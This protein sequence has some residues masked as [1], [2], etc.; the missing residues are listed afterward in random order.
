MITAGDVQFEP[1]MMRKVWWLTTAVGVMWAGDASLQAEVLNDVVL[2]VHRRVQDQP[3]NWWNVRDVA[4]LYA[5]AWNEAKR[6]RAVRAILGPLGLSD[7]EFHSGQ[8]GFSD[9]IV[10]QLAGS[11]LAFQLPGEALGLTEAII[12]GVDMSYGTFPTAHLYR[13]F[14]ATYWCEDNVGF[15]AIGAGSWHARSQLMLAGYHATQPSEEALWRTYTAKRRA[16]VAPGVGNKGTD[17]FSLGPLPGQRFE[18]PE[19]WMKQLAERYDRLRTKET[20]AAQFEIAG[21]KTW[22]EE[23]IAAQ[24]QAKQSS[25]ASASATEAGSAQRPDGLPKQSSMEKKE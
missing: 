13:F 17:M 23:M 3:E 18:I 24:A 10:Q 21:I 11:L 8:H 14:N 12:V 6:R 16:E 15:A 20:D 7:D 1:Q 9:S 25:E 2:T 4:D 5:T 22:I 19:D